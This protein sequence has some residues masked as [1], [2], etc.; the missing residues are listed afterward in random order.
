MNNIKLIHGGSAPLEEALSHA[1]SN[2]TPQKTASD[3]FHANNTNADSKHLLTV[4]SAAALKIQTKFRKTHIKIIKPD[5]IREKIEEVLRELHLREESSSTSK[6]SISRDSSQSS[7]LSEERSVPIT[8]DTL[9]DE[10]SGSNLNPN[11]E[12]PPQGMPS[13]EGSSEFMADALSWNGTYGSN[14][15]TKE[16]PVNSSQSMFQS[17]ESSAFVATNSYSPPPLPVGRM[18]HSESEATIPPPA[19]AITPAESSK[20]P[21]KKEESE[22][23]KRMK[24]EY[25]KSFEERSK[26]PAFILAHG[27]M[28]LVHNPPKTG[29][30]RIGDANDSGAIRAWVKKTPQN[31]LEVEVIGGKIAEGKSSK[32]YETRVFEISL[33]KPQKT[34]TTPSNNALKRRVLLRSEDR[35]H[36]ERI[37]MATQLLKDKFGDDEKKLMIAGKL[38]DLDRSFTQK[39]QSS[40]DKEFFEAS[41]ELMDGD[42]ETQKNDLTSEEKKNILSDTA[43]T[44]TLLHS[45]NL[46]HSDVKPLNIFLKE[47]RG[48]LGDIEDL[49]DYT[50]PAHN[51]GAVREF[52]SGL[53]A[54]KSTPFDDIYALAVSIQRLFGDKA[55][56]K[57]P[58]L[59]QLM[60][61]SK[62]IAEIAERMRND[63]KFDTEEAAI[64]DSMNKLRS[65]DPDKVKE[66]FEDLNIKYP[67]FR[68]FLNSVAKVS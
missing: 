30:I 31:T 19:A 48:Y 51:T 38:E 62:N 28:T 27:I 59:K 54:I 5:Q 1:E 44:L 56:D 16:N 49:V 29:R 32:V 68:E 45:K 39:I 42:L 11:E 3:A 55:A 4:E 35:E 21:P 2:K 65:Q 8:V 34:P 37:R 46:M 66:A 47:K 64:A 17:E 14:P 6:L 25:L 53:A 63:S 26:D 13:P 9:S 36:S 50:N 57:F 41:D 20:S 24:A 40:K 61:D 10:T 33:P 18:S 23:A 12:N 67:S 60:E 43:K 22:Y 52:V 58:K 15:N 7:D